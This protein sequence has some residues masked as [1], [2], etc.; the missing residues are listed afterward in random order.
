MPDGGGG[1]DQRTAEVAVDV[2]EEGQA[3]VLVLSLDDARFGSASK[4]AQV[5]TDFF[6]IFRRKSSRNVVFD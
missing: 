1:V 3:V 2:G 5:K 4:T 6:L